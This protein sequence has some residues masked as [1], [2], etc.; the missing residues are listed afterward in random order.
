MTLARKAV[1]LDPANEL[2]EFQS[3]ARAL[4]THGL[5]TERYRSLA[6]WP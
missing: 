6:P 4:I 2:A 1:H 3:T 5:V